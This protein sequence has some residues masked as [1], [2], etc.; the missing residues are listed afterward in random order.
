[1]INNVNN[2]NCSLLIFACK[3]NQFD[4]IDLLLSKSAIINN[5][6]M[7]GNSLLFYTTIYSN[8][9]VVSLLLL[10]EI[11]IKSLLSFNNWFDEIVVLWI[12]NGMNMNIQTNITY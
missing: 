5:K 7:N 9:K 2:Y 3:L 1:M 4:I 11:T 6:N 12:K 8:Y 10:K